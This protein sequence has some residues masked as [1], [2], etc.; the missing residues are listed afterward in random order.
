HR[1]WGV[2]LWTASLSLGALLL[3][4]LAI[5]PVARAQSTLSAI[6]ED[7]ER[8]ARRA[9]PCVLTII[10]QSS[11]ASRAAQARRTV[12]RVGSGVAVSTNGVL[13]TASVVLGADH[14]VVVTDNHLQVEAHVVGMDTVRNLALLRA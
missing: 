2:R 9:R 10:A 3:L 8:I 1:G 7:V 14:V 12:N 13:T 6:E 4:G 11:S 5:V